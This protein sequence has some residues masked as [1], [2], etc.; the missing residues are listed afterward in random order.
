MNK[1][2]VGK[3]ER[4]VTE[5]NMNSNEVLIINNRKAEKE[6]PLITSPFSLTTNRNKT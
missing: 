6:T 4:K 3:N 1:L 2:K 5:I